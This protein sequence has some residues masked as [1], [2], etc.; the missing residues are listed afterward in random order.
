MGNKKKSPWRTRKCSPAIP[1]DIAL[2]KGQP[3]PTLYDLR[4]LKRRGRRKNGRKIR[5]SQLNTERLTIMF[6]VNSEIVVFAVFAFVWSSTCNGEIRF[7][8]FIINFMLQLEK[9]SIHLVEEF[10]GDTEWPN[11]EGLFDLSGFSHGS[12]FQVVS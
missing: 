6:V 7:P 1:S 3:Y 12:C 10:S 8:V 5:K 11:R 2:G 9:S 4:S